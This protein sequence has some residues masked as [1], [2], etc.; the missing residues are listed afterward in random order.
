M[1]LDYKMKNKKIIFLNNKSKYF[2]IIKSDIIL[3]FILGLLFTL[4]LYLLIN[5]NNTSHN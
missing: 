4:A 1:Y 5:F 3:I 2:R